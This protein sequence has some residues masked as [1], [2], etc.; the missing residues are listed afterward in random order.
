MEDTIAAISTP[1]G[2]GGIAIVRVSGPHALNVAGAI[3]HSPRGNVSQFPTHTIHYG[4]IVQAGEIVD[5]VMLTVF[6]GPHSYTTEDTVEIN[7][8]GGVLTAQSVLSLC[9][10]HGARMAEPGE[11]TKRAFLNGRLDLTQAEAVMDL[12]TARTQRAQAVAARML[13]GHL[14]RRVETLREEV[15]RLLAHVEAY[16]DFPEEDIPPTTSE[17]WN[18]DLDRSIVL[19]RELLSTA[20]EGRVL[21]EGILVAIIGRPNVGKSSVMNALL[22]RDRSIVTPVAGTTRDSIEDIITIGGVPIRLTDT[23]GYRKARGMVEAKGVNRTLDI[24]KHAEVILHVID[25]SRPFSP[26]DVEL[27]RLCRSKQVIQVYNKTD[28]PRKLSATKLL[29]TNHHIHI[30]AMTEKGLPSLRNVIGRIANSGTVGAG[31]LDIAINERHTLALTRAMDALVAA[32]VAQKQSIGLEIVSQ[33]L[34]L[35]LNAIG[36]VVGM[37]TTEDILDQIF[38]TFC[39]GK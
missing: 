14:Y 13:E 38:S 16:L 4:K 29:Q 37:T 15:V 19:L 12:I 36:E 26:S 39:I 31:D 34:R 20:H 23:A 1:L 17:K 3:F 2:M 18:A 25:T 6:R 11:F 10:Q 28:L 24:V 27:T 33:H 22:G 30:S 7:C 5:Q 9:L 35:G 32:K 8:H 21:R